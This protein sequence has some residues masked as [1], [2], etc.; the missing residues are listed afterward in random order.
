MKPTENVNETVFD[1]IDA[2]ESGA[3]SA[4]G[5]DET[6]AEGV[7]FPEVPFHTGNDPALRLL[8][9]VWDEFPD[10]VKN[11]ILQLVNSATATGW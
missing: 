5:S 2:A 4:G 6:R 1:S 11:Q 10:S 3:V 7:A 9:E 8:L